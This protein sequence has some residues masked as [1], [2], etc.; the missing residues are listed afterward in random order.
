MNYYEFIEQNEDRIIPV[1]SYSHYPYETVTVEYVRRYD[2][3]RMEI[4]LPNKWTKHTMAPGGDTCPRCGNKLI[5]LMKHKDYY[6]DGFRFVGC[7]NYPNCT[8]RK[9][10][11]PEYRSGHYNPFGGGSLDIDELYDLYGVKFFEYL[12][13]NINWCK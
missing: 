8:Y 3:K 7:S 13:N 12:H 6:K 10:D 5:I 2:N 9:S 4:V 11:R 1:C